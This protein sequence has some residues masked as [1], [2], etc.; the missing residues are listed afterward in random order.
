MKMNLENVQRLTRQAEW[1]LLNVR[2]PRFDIAAMREALS[3]TDGEQLC[4]AGENAPL[5]VVSEDGL[6]RIIAE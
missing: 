6:R 4:L 3:L 5:S 1:N 2:L